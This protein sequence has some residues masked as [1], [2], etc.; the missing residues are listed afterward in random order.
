MD[1]R[2]NIQF[3]L[4]FASYTI[5]FHHSSG[6]L[7]LGIHILPISLVMQPFLNI[8]FE[9]NQREKYAI[10]H[11]AFCNCEAIKNVIDF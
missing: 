1:R 7:G 11:F 5:F 8:E 2:D 4:H 6:N 9:P 10:L 3:L